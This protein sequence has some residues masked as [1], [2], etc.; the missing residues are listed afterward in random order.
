[1]CLEEEQLID[2]LLVLGLFALGFVSLVDRGWVQ[3]LNV[4][5]VLVAWRIR[6]KKIFIRGTWKLIP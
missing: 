2:R 5:N 4:K 6:I 1:M 3:T